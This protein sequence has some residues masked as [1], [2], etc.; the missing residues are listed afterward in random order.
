M[1]DSPARLSGEIFNLPALSLRN[2]ALQFVFT[3]RKQP[4]LG[5]D[6]RTAVRGCQR[7]TA[8]W[9][10]WAE[11]LKSEKKRFKLVLRLF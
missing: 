8:N 5:A 11:L 10:G 4:A 6:F 9:V 3:L 7:R 1:A 2:G